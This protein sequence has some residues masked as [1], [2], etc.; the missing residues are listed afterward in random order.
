MQISNNSNNVL[1]SDLYNIDSTNKKEN[2]DK[3]D[4][5]MENK[6]KEKAK[7]QEQENLLENIDY[8]ARTGFTKDELELINNK[9]EELQKK[10]AESGH[11]PQNIEE[12]L[13]NQKADLQAAIYEV[14]GKTVNLDKESIE[15]FI[16]GQNTTEFKSISTDESLRLVDEFKNK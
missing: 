14:T 11:V 9:F 16:K 15:S 12:V 10:R 1:D 7:Q 8:I 13:A 2:K 6:Q 5:F 3:F 4:L